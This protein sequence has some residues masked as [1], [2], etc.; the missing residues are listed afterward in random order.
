M[1]ASIT[2]TTVIQPFEAP[3]SIRSSIAETSRCAR[4]INESLRHYRDRLEQVANSAFVAH[5]RSLRAS[6]VA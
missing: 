1:T 5:M 6:V 3:L 2:A 4:E